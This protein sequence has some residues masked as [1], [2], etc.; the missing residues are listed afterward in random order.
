[1][2]ADPR[3]SRSHA[4]RGNASRSRFATTSMRQ[5]AAERQ[6]ISFPRRAWEQT[7]LLDER[8]VVVR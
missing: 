1:M 4:L 8:T 3:F 2:F 5:I 7:A 6:I